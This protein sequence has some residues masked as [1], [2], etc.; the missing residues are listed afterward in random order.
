MNES[1]VIDQGA[2][3]SPAQQVLPAFF[4]MVGLIALYF[5]T[6]FVPPGI[7]TLLTSIFALVVIFVTALAR[8]N[9]ITIHMTGK[10]WHL[11]RF[12][13]VLAG[14]GA[15][16]SMVL[17]IAQQT[18]PTWS[19]VMLQLGVAFTWFTTPGMPPWWKFI[20]GKEA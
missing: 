16:A 20:A 19:Q 6:V 4:L 13:L 18:Y 5:L 9:D 10:R 2:T 12:G 17:P 11:R 7:V 15:A 3:K 8:V 14:M 1:N